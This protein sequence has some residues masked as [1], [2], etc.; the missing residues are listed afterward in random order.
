MDCNKCGTPILPGENYCRFC[1]TI[2]DF[3]VRKHVEVKPE[4]IDFNIDD[5]RITK[6]ISRHVEEFDKYITG[7]MI[8]LQEMKELLEKHLTTIEIIK[9]VCVA[10]SKLKKKKEKLLELSSFIEKLLW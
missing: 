2:G 9:G 4:I 8:C 1:G 3:S 10:G 7:E 5:E 6:E